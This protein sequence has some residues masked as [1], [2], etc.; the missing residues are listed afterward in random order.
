VAA[1][2]SPAPQ[3]VLGP[4]LRYVGETEATIWVET[5][6]ACL[7]EILGRQAR[8]F[9]VAGHHYGLV[10]I[11][12]LRPGTECEYQVSL[13]GVRCWPDPGSP[14][15]PSLLWTLAP[16][17]PVRL[18]FGSCRI[19]ELPAPRRRRERAR[20]RPGPGRPASSRSAIPS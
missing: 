9:Q 14:F 20:R 10:V 1:G 8:I 15:P 3:L 13:D 19:A 17:R 6:R 11:D 5:D 4:L 7:V 16:G 12:G 18:A 2:G